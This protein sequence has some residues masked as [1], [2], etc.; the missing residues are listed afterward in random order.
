[1]NDQ[2]PLWGGRGPVSV[3]EV[4]L[5]HEPRDTS[6]LAAWRAWPRSG[7]QRERVLR[8]VIDRGDHGATDDEIQDALRLS[9]NSERPRRLELVERGWLVDSGRRRPS[10]SH[11]PAIVWVAKP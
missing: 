9:G 5:S 8:W 4:K 2:L 6:V 1:V 3:P 10:Y 7:T 11:G